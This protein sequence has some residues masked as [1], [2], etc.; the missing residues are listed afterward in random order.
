MT[1]PLPGKLQRWIADNTLGDCVYPLPALLWTRPV[2]GLRAP[3]V[4]TIPVYGK[5]KLRIAMLRNEANLQEGVTENL[6]NSA[7]QSVNPIETFLRR[8]PIVGRFAHVGYLVLSFGF[9]Q[10][11]G[12]GIQRLVVFPLVKHQMGPKA[13]GA[14]V[15][16]MSFAAVCYM[17]SSNGQNSTVFR[18]HSWR[19]PKEK[20]ILYAT[21]FWITL[22]VSLVLALGLI[23]ASPYLSVAYGA[24]VGVFSW[25]LV[26]MVVSP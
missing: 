12:L 19:K 9:F 5:W 18:F 1:L 26:P 7:G 11:C 25:I 3:G 21:G 15:L 22:G 10:V 23:V 20:P 8:V 4:A 17:V 2:Q 13:F 24:D 16:A 14:F 6:P